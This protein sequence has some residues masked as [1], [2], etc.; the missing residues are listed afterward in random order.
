MKP[1]NKP[2]EFFEK[3]NEKPK[4]LFEYGAKIQA[5]QDKYLKIIIDL[6]G[7]FCDVFPI[8]SV[9]YK[10]PAGDVEIAVC[11]KDGQ[12]TKVIEILRKEFGDP[13]TE[14]PEFVKFQIETEEYE[15]SINVYQGY[16]AMFC[17]NFTKYMLDHKDLIKEYKAIKEKYCFSKREYQK[18]KY[19]FYDKIIIDIPEDYAK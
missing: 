7:E 8:G 14:K 3:Y 17:K 15:V 4:K 2:A 12:F 16:E 11:P 9:V 19:L 5:L 10:I 6:V 1:P 13:E 18:Q